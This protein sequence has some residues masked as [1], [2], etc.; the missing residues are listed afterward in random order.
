MSAMRS[1]AAVTSAVRPA[2]A[3]CLVIVAAA[4]R[5]PAPPPPAPDATAP[6]PPLDAAPAPRPDATPAPATLDDA[7]AGLRA[8]GLAAAA[9]VIAGRVAQAQPKMRLTASEARTAALAVRDL[10]GSEPVR[11]LHDVMPRS[12]VELARAVAERDLPP[13]DAVAIAAYLVQFVAVLDFERLAT[14]DDNHSHVTGRHWHD[15]DYSGEGMTWQRQRA[16]WAPRGVADFR[17]VASIHAYFVGAEPLR[18][19]RR[20]YRPRGKVADV[21][22]PER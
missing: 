20:V 18:H 1:W 17:T 12:T 8:T 10:A 16:Y 15:I 9:D 5:A 13:A 14:F 7:L 4:C 22:S 3:A 11:A 21:P 6:R 19:W 2:R